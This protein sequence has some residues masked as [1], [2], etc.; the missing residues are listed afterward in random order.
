MVTRTFEKVAKE[1]GYFQRPEHAMKTVDRVKQL[2]PT[3]TRV[4]IAK[5]L[6]RHPRNIG[7]LCR[8]YGIVTKPAKKTCPPK[9]AVGPKCGPDRIAEIQQVLDTTKFT[10][11]YAITKFFNVS[12]TTIKRWRA[13]GLIK[14]STPKT[15]PDVSST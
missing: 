9:P 7:N 3:H 4:E 2:A 13:L 12:K 5:I 10:S 6:E 14:F 8:K 11:I 15:K 1:F